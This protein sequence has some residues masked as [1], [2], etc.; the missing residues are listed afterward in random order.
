MNLP[1]KLSMLRI[2]MIPFFVVFAL[3]PALWAQMVALALFIA[4][5]V[6]DL[7]DGKIARKRG[8]VTNFGK[9][10]DPIA[11]K[12]LVMSA[13]V[14]LT[15]QGR[16]PSWVCIVMLAREFAISGFRLVAADAGKVI[17]AGW[18]GKVKTV[19]QMSAVIGLFFFVPLEGAPILGQPGMILAQIAMYLA[20]FMTLWSGVDYI[21]RNFDCIRDM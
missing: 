2:C 17:A 11:D 15:G 18:L 5:S 12:L 14:V 6:T 19:T 7:L 4:A 9:F 16:M 8:L 20:T 10:I 1:N 3:M 13:L 21:V